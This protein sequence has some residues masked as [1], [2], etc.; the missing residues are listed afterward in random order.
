MLR[1]Q[2]RPQRLVFI[3]TRAHALDLDEEVT[4][5]SCGTQSVRAQPSLPR[6]LDS[7]AGRKCTSERTVRWSP[8]RT[9]AG[10]RSEAG[11]HGYLKTR[12]VARRC[13]QIL[14]VR[15]GRID[16]TMIGWGG[17]IDALQFRTAKVAD[18]HG[19][20]VQTSAR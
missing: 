18:D 11:S 1:I 2:P 4:G 16:V 3:D 14:N 20:T 5:S 13:Y 6:D 12:P 10:G 9:C 8:P 15:G 7:S 17:G 19:V